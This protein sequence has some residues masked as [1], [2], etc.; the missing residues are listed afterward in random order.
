MTDNPNKF[1]QQ[2]SANLKAPSSDLKNE[3]DTYIYRRDLTT[4]MNVLAEALKN[5]SAPIKVKAVKI[6]GGCS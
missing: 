6:K 1:R 5:L 2:F 4:K 3:L